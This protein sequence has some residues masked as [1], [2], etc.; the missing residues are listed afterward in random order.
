MTP[1]L[2]K[3]LFGDQ[4][5]DVSGLTQKVDTKRTDVTSVQKVCAGSSL[6]K[7]TFRCFLCYVPVLTEFFL[8]NVYISAGV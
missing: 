8:L 2:L 7:K 4:K 5:N 6:L 3:K 1:E